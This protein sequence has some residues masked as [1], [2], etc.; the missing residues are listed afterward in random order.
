MNAKRLIEQLTK[1]APETEIILASDAEGNEFNQ[2]SQVYRH[3]DL[4]YNIMDDEISLNT[5][6]DLDEFFTLKDYNKGKDCV[7][8]YPK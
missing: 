4:R 8:L 1:L 6:E 2:L 5:L 3:K 7:G